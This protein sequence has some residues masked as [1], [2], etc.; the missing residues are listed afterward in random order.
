M[1]YTVI[2]GIGVIST[3]HLTANPCNIQTLNNVIMLCDDIE[4]ATGGYTANDTLLTL[5][6]PEMFPDTEIVVPIC[7]TEGTT[8]RTAPLTINLAGEFSLPFSYAAG[9]IVHLNGICWHV[10]SKYYTPAI[11]NIYNNGT[12]PLTAI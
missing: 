5:S 10:N 3:S 2:G 12:S 4:I 1:P 7:V 11:G 8:T 9:T 6:D